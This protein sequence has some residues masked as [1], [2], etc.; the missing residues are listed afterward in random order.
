MQIED[1]DAKAILLNNL[2][3]NYDNAIFTLSQL[4]S[5]SL[6]K[7]VE[8][9]LTEEKRIKIS[10]A[11]DNLQPEMTLFSRGW[12]HKNKKSVNCFY[13][14]KHGHTTLNCKTCAKDLLNGK[15]KQY[16]NIDIIEDLPEEIF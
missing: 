10:V 8:S 2:P 5:K 3:S 14:Q 12:V 13:C 16:T 11:K 15:L 9:L 4:S 1:E 6:D 7:M